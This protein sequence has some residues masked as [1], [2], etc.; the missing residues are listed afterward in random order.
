MRVCT[1]RYD[2]VQTAVV[3]AEW[4]VAQPC[5]LGQPAWSGSLRRKT[6]TST[7]DV[8]DH[9]ARTVTATRHAVG[10][11]SGE[12]IE[13]TYNCPIWVEMFAEGSTPMC[14]VLHFAHGVVGKWIQQHRDG[15]PPVVVHFTDGE[16]QDGD[17][18]PYADAVRRLA[19]SQGKLHT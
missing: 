3:L 8:R 14:H 16:S 4:M 6:L 7:T 2:A 10:E 13:S 15:S 19:T 12:A 9:P 18:V 17:P 11:G 1:R 5:F